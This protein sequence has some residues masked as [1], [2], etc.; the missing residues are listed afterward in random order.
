[1]YAAPPVRVSLGRGWAWP[2]F[3]GAC[4]AVATANVVGWGL[5]GGEIEP[6]LPPAL[7]GGL[8]SGSIAAW[9]VHRLHGAGDLRWD[10]ASWQWRGSDGQAH[11]AIDLGRWMLLRFEPSDGARRWLAASRAQM[12]GS[13]PAL[14]AALY[15]RR[16]SE[17]VDGPPA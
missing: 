5:L 6:A 8:C 17:A 11:V 4:V 2:A 9:R 13:W 3:V 15:S 10:G 1:M 14:R 12:I 16:P 7:L